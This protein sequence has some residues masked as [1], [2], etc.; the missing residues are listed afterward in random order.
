MRS[1][2]VRLKPSAVGPALDRSSRKLS[3]TPFGRA[4]VPEVNRMTALS[5]APASAQA[6]LGSQAFTAAKK[7]SPRR[8]SQAPSGRHGADTA[9]RMSSSPSPSSHNTMRGLSTGRMLSSWLRFISTWTVQMVA[10]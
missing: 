2:A 10:P 7:L 1:C 4:L 9:L 6:S 3:T 5:S 8:S